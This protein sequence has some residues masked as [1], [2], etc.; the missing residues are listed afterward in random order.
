[1]IFFPGR[2]SLSER[3]AHLFIARL[4]N[5]FH[6]H[7]ISSNTVRVILI[8]NCCIYTEQQGA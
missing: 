4:P 8:V 7:L 5:K 3:V 1:L 6:M 2:Q